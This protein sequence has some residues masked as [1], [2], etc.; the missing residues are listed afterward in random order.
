ML[1]LRSI[2]VSSFVKR[3]TLGVALVVV[4]LVAFGNIVHDISS[5]NAETKAVHSAIDHD[6]LLWN[7]AG[8]DRHS[9]ECD[10]TTFRHRNPHRGLRGSHKDHASHVN[11]PINAARDFLP[12][13]KRGPRHKTAS[14][15]TQICGNSTI[16][17]SPPINDYLAYRTK[18]LYFTKSI[19]VESSETNEKDSIQQSD[20][21]TLAI[22][23]NEV[24]VM[25]ALLASSL[26]VL[27]FYYSLHL[28]T[29]LQWWL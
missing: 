15:H 1:Y 12:V 4:S 27:V 21:T 24:L 8:H 14:M 18:K 6:V 29:R 28:L 22:V 13:F 26:A 20:N 16:L 9:K 19:D 10:N 2:R 5:P 11:S 3:L 25:T 23:R 17:S 7:R